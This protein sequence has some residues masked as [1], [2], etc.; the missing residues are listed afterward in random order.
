MT[1]PWPKNFSIEANDKNELSRAFGGRGSDLNKWFESRSERHRYNNGLEEEIYLLRRFLFTLANSD[2]LVYPLEINNSESPDF[3]CKERDQRYGIEVTEATHPS[4][5]REM[6]EFDRNRQ[7]MLLGTYGGRFQGG[8]DGN[9]PERFLTDDVIDAI[10]RKA[11]KIRCKKYRNLSRIN[12]LIY[13]NSN[14]ER[15]IFEERE[16]ITLVH[17]ELEERLPSLTQGT[18]ISQISLILGSKLG[19]DL[20]REPLFLGLRDEL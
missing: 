17:S 8:A 9:D 1:Y 7:P 12:L 4:D 18:N 13:A 11:Q 3:L 19:F 5:Q 16:A 14:A 2:K 20:G 15:L 6:T 10:K